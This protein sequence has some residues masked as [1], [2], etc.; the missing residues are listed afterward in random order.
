MRSTPFILEGST[1]WKPDFPMSVSREREFFTLPIH[2]HDFVEIQ[3][4]AEG[5]GFHYIEDERLL[6]EKGDL[7]IIPVGTRHVYRPSSEASKDELI[8]YNCFFSPEVSDIVSRTYPL[9]NEIHSLLTINKP[10]YRRYKDTFHEGRQHM[11]ALHR[12]YR[13]K[14]PGHEA[15]LYALLTRLLVYLHRLESSLASAPPAYAKFSSVL[16]YIEDNYSRSLTL[17]DAAGIVYVSPGYMQKMFIG[18]TGQSFTEYTQN[19]RIKKSMELLAGTSHTVKEIAERVGYRDLKFFYA[20][21]RKKTG[22]SPRQYRLGI[23]NQ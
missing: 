17:S 7:F 14:Q 12:E 20:L 23:R 18:A 21:F 3:Y 9:P 11:E 19:L 13:T 5:K 6:V 8:V 16:E 15:A 1:F 10:A 2:A 22:Q 4:V